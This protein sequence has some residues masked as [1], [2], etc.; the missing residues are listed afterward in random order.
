VEA[1]HTATATTTANS[2]I[3]AV[4]GMRR[5]GGSIAV[6]PIAARSRCAPARDGLCCRSMRLRQRVHEILEG[7][8]EDAVA[9]AINI[10]MLALILTNVAAVVLATV[11]SIGER[12]AATFELFETVSLAIFATEYALRLWSCT[13][14]PRFADP[15]TGRLRQAVQAMTLIDLLAILPGLLP[16]TDIDLRTLRALRLLRVL[17]V[18]KLTRYSA[19]LQTFVS[20]LR[21]K[22]PELLSILFVLLLLLVMSASL[23]YFLER[24]TN[25]AFDSIPT[26]MW[27]GIV[28]FTTVGYGDLTPVTPA[29]RVVGGC[30]AV[31][32]IGMFAIP[33]GLLGAAFTAEIDRRKQPPK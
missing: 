3:E 31:L 27:W 16:F 7:Q 18:L 5:R 9:R 28:T 10:G 19:S 20:V 15:V 22:A 33:A 8:A 24:D 23:M 13:A 30:V 32:G 17:R 1:N 26:A 12:H 11:P 6:A 14:D 29:G 4:L 2:Q 21:S 25:P